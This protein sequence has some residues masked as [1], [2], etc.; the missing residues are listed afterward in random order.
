MNWTEEELTRIGSAERAELATVGA[1][2]RLRRPVT[3]WVVRAGDNLYVRSWLGREGKWYR[4]LGGRG[5][6]H[7]SA[8]GVEKDVV[9]VPTGG[10]VNDAV[11]GGYRGKYRRYTGNYLEPMIAPSARETTLEI[12]PR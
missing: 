6:A 9:L 12:R 11:D 8:G 3:V 7:I 4:S 2:G 5:E 10:T 1:S